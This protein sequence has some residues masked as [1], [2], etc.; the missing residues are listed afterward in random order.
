MI[1]AIKL[2][3]CV[4]GAGILGI[5][6]YKLCYGKKPYLIILFKIDKNSELGFYCTI[7][8]FDLTVRLLMKGG[9]KSPI[10]AKEIV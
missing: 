10:N 1:S 9:E 3:K 5:V 4:A 8:S 7:L 2:E 6:L